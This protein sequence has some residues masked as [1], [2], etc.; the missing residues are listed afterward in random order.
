[1]KKEKRIFFGY[2]TDEEENM[3]FDELSKIDC[4]GTLHQKRGNEEKQVLFKSENLQIN[5][6]FFLVSAYYGCDDKRGIEFC[7]GLIEK[8]SQ[9]SK[10]LGLLMQLKDYWEALM[11]VVT[12]IDKKNYSD[13]VVNKYKKYYKYIYEKIKHL[14]EII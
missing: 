5:E 6:K 12:F 4:I 9:N 3:S 13:D 11:I 8:Y 2:F 7:E 14:T 10:V 1:M